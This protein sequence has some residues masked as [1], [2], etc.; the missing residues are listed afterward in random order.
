MKF[1]GTI[2]ALLMVGFLW[3]GWLTYQTIYFP[4]F[5]AKPEKRSAIDTAASLSKVGTIY[6]AT[7]V[8][9]EIWKL[10]DSK[11]D[12]YIV[13]HAAP[14]VQNQAYPVFNCLSYNK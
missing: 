7:G 6:V 12:C 1:W 8:N 5:L 10:S 11:A 2:L 14:R 13:I 4:D 3:M 9:L